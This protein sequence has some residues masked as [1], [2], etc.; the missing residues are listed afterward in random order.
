MTKKWRL[1]R[2]DTD[3]ADWYGGYIP[4]LLR[5]CAEGKIPDTMAFFTINKPSVF[6][7]RYC[8]VLR[9]INYEACVKHKIKITR[10][11]GAGGG[12][13]Y[14]EPGTE[15]A[16]IL[17]WNKDKNPD[18]PVQPDLV[19]M[20]FLGTGADIISET[21]KVPVRFRPLNDIECWD[22]ARKVWRK[23]AGTGSSGLFGAVGTGW[24]P[25]S[26]KT[27]DLIDEI[28]VVPA[29]KFSDKAL[30][31]VKSRNWTFEEAGVFPKGL[32]EIDRVRDAWFDITLKTLK[33]TFDVEVEEGE[34]TDAEKQYFKDFT[35]Q[36]H[37]EPWIFARSAEKKYEEIPPGTSLG[38][39]FVK[40]PAGPLIRAYILREGDKIK[41]MMFTGTMHMTPSDG[42][43]KLEKELIGMKIDESAITAKV[44]EW[45]G[46]G[47]QIGML[48]PSKLVGV[49][50]EAC[51]LSYKR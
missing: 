14:N 22:P 34:W 26:I 13:M 24:V 46:T 15:P 32:N 33:K 7:Q 10:S 21:F 27:S 19:M 39:A 8:D 49:I 6:I 42:L 45:F 3:I 41:D 5:A 43:E 12:V 36:F 31:D 11:I 47:V 17:I 23:M 16:V 4:A 35:T 37:S 2:A 25:H 18:I 30:K 1:V 9:D 48:E 20:K 50:M 28:L 40:V 44:S 29:E 51:K 38:K